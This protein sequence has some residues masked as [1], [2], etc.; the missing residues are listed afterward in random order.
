[1]IKVLSQLQVMKIKFNYNEIGVFIAI[2]I[3]L[4]TP[5]LIKEIAV[6]TK[7]LSC[8]LYALPVA[9]L[10]ASI[11]KKWVF[12]LILTLFMITSFLEV[13]MVGLFGSYITSG[14]I[15]AILT[16]NNEE[17]TGFV[18]TTLHALPATIPVIISWIAALSIKRGRSIVWP[19]ILGAFVTFIFS[20]IFIFLNITIKWDGRITSKFYIDQN[21]LSHPPYNFV[22]QSI[23]AIHQ[24]YIKS[25][26]KDAD[27]MTFG[28]KKDLINENEIYV[29]AV[30]ESMRYDNLSIGGYKRNTTPQLSELKN[31]ILFSDYYSTATLTMYSV[32]QIITRATADS[33]ELNYKEKSIFQPFK[34]C[35][36]KTF[37]ICCNNL[38]TYEKY[39]T[40]GV[41]SLYSVPTDEDI[42][43]KID[44][45]SSLYPKT[46]YIV[47]FYGN[48]SPYK[49]FCPKDNIF[50]SKKKMDE[51]DKTILHADHVISNIIKTIDKPGYIS[52]YVMMSDHG[53][54]FTSEKFS[55]HGA[56][57][58]PSKEEYHVPLIIWYN[59]N[60]ADL[61]PEKAAYLSERKDVPV[62]A[63]N[64]FYTV[65]D[66]AGIRLSPQYSKPEWAITSNKFQVH[67]RNLL[68]PDGKN[69]LTLK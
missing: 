47:Q 30:G 10:I 56:S 22:N 15:L 29:L 64:I 28:A 43:L 67:T 16:T 50:G 19:N 35:G 69:C 26:I 48:H 65:C 25:Y 6:I 18:S 31:L 8:L 36:F 57:C 51:Y 54:D 7:M 11:S 44:S 62:N 63:D 5:I 23:N 49:N 3:M 27:D 52:T 45:L 12:N 66:M 39:L 59:T 41:D 2:F 20:A 1:M 55:G 21:V 61:F 32:P 42:R 53:E 40:N 37:A 9:F 46:F 13:M 68:T 24:L 60:W 4:A 33:F 17:A 38:L 14:N 58:N 34:E